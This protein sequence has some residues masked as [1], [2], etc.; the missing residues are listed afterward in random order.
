MKSYRIALLP[1]DGIGKEVVP[2][3]MHVL[4]T[5]ARTY[6]FS[7]VNESFPW[8]CEYY[9]QHGQMMP[10]DGIETLRKFDAIFMGTVGFPALVPDH[11]SLHG[12]MLKIRRAF[13]QYVNVRPHRLLAGVKGPLRTE[14]AFDILVIR[15]NSEGEYIGAGGRAHV[16]TP[17][18][19]AVETAI[20]TRTGV[21]R[22]LRYG[23]EQARRRRRHLTSCT[24][25]N[26]QRNSMVFWDDV[27]NEV[28]KDYPDVELF[29]CH[30]D[31]L[32]ARFVTHPHTLD[33]VVASNLF[34]DILTDIGAAIQG[35]LGFAPSGNIDP[36]GRAPSMFEAVHGSAPDIYGRQ[37]AN[38]I[39]QIWAGAMMLEHLGETQAAR[40]VVAAVE[41]VTATRTAATPDM[42]GTNSTMEVAA[43]IA[44][45]IQ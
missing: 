20:F 40:A 44:K 7:L 2:A 8:S 17:H 33:V 39:A 14:K 41:A 15:E 38:P 13:D 18:E 30:V 5:A 10:E 1:A 23:F 42:G 45:A 4:D 35:G 31:A 28:A 34:G 29:R 26:A 36:T 11:I 22:V 25:S 6:G 24:K 27:T 21:E 16:G 12:M 19:V 37:I 32:A 3:A 43:A 9:L